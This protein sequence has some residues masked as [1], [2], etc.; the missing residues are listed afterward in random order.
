M[1]PSVPAWAREVTGDD[2]LLAEN[3]KLDRVITILRSVVITL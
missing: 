3:S 2:R 1:D